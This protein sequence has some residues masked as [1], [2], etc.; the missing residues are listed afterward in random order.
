ML[1]AVTEESSLKAIPLL[2]TRFGTLLIANGSMVSG[3]DQTD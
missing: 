2:P 1:K 3:S